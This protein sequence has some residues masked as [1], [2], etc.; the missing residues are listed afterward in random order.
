MS[1]HMQ[2]AVRCLASSEPA[3]RGSTQKQRLLQT[4]RQKILVWEAPGGVESIGNRSLN[5][6]HDSLDAV[7]RKTDKCLVSPMSDK[8]L[9]IVGIQAH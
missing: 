8:V 5:K 9:G 2:R 7:S 6:L 4:W 1:R 3:A